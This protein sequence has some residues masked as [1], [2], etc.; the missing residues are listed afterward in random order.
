MKVYCIQLL[1][2]AFIFFSVS[3]FGQNLDKET[4]SVKYIHLPENPLPSNLTSYSRK[5]TL[6]KSFYD[7]SKK[8]SVEKRLLEA[9][10]IEGYSIVDHSDDFSIEIET[11]NFKTLGFEEKTVEKVKVFDGQRIIFTHFS[12]ELIYKMPVFFQVKVNGKNIHSGYL[13]NSNNYVRIDTPALR[14]EEEREFWKNH[15]SKDF[16]NELRAKEFEK[17]CQEIH[18]YLSNNYAYTEKQIQIPVLKLESTA[19]RDYTAYNSICEDMIKAF[20]LIEAHKGHSGKDYNVEA[21]QVIDKFRSMLKEVDFKDKKAL[22]NKKTSAYIAANI[23]MLSIWLNDFKVSLECMK[24]AQANAG[25]EID[26]EKYK[27]LILSRST[28]LK[29]FK[30]SVIQ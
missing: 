25:K 20:H 1:H 9:T 10:T 28:K 21:E 23:G 24:Y 26:S 18:S 7:G 2:F 4:I 14:S 27:Q 15:L 22:Y 12:Y 3:L 6:P 29:K 8:D 17:H 16:I 19:K 11:N 13:N 5:I 30:A